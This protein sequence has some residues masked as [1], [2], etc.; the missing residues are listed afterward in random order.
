MERVHNRRRYL[1]KKGGLEECRRNLGRIQR[2][3]ECRSKEI[4]ENRYGRGERL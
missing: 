1:G 4:R 3:D 2:E